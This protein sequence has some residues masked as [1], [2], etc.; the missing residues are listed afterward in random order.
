MCAKTQMCK[1]AQLM[2][3][4]DAS[5]VPYVDLYIVAGIYIYIYI[6]MNNSPVCEKLIAV[7]SRLECI[8]KGSLW[9]STVF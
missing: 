6:Y 3:R 5:T 2:K 9:R 4:R 7:F 8:S 1:Y